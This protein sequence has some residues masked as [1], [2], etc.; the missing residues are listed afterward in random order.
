MHQTMYGIGNKPQSK[1][2]TI[3]AHRHAEKISPTSE[4][5]Q[6]GSNSVMGTQKLHFNTTSK[7]PSR[8]NSMMSNSDPVTQQHED[9]V[10]A[11]NEEWEK[12]KSDLNKNEEQKISGT[13]QYVERDP[14][15]AM[16]GFQAFDLEQ[17][18][19]QKLLSNTGIKS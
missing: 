16:S 12:V 5:S 1:H 9:N 11:L 17:Y 3:P 18:W 13:T 4:S 8:S 14:N 7:R 10:T 6:W 2:K 19:G 15:P